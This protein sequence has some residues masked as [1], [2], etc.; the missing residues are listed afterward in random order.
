MSA[1]FKR[2]LNSLMLSGIGP[3]VTGAILAVLFLFFIFNNLMG[4][5]TDTGASM[6]AASV[7]ALTFAVPILCMR[8][9][10]GEK[11]AKTDQ[12]ILTAPVKVR[13]YVLGK[14]FALS[15]ILLIPTGFACFLSTLI[16]LFGNAEIAVSLTAVFGFYLYAV[17]L[18][19]ICMFLS[20]LTESP[21][22]AAMFSFI[23]ILLGVLLGGAYNN[24]PVLWLRRALSAV[25]NFS[26][27]LNSMMYGTLDVT[28]VVYFVS[29]TCLFLFLC[30]AAINKRRY[31]LQGHGRV[32]AAHSLSLIL[33]AS[34]AVMF[35]NIFVSS[36]PEEKMSIDVTSD[37]L[38]SL[39]DESKAVARSVSSPITLHFIAPEGDDFGKDTNIER[40]L[41]EFASENSLIKLSYE[42]PIINPRFYADYSKDE[43][44]SSSVVVVNE[45]NGAYRAIDANDM[46]LS[47]MDF[48][49]FSYVMTGYDTEGQIT[50]AL[51]YVTDPVDE[52][53]VAYTLTGHGESDIDPGFLK[54]VDR[55]LFTLDELDLDAVN[56][57]P[58]D[59]A[60]IIIN[61]PLRDITA[62]EK[63]S[64]VAYI[65]GGGDL[66]V[67]C[68]FDT[69]EK[70]DNLAEVLKLYGVKEK[71]G[72]VVETA[73]DMFYFA[74]GNSMPYYLFPK[75][76][77]DDMTT[78]IENGHLFVPLS[79][80]FEYDEGNGDTKVKPLITTSEI[81]YIHMDF[82]TEQNLARRDSDEEGVFTLALKAENGDSKAVIYGSSEMFTS[83]AD[84]LSTGNNARL[85]G[86]TLIALNDETALSVSIPIKR[87]NETL[88]VT[89]SRMM[90]ISA[91]LIAIVFIIWIA[92]LAVWL[93]RR[94]L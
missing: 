25:F 73:K 20:S 61:A 60:L 19:S 74:G 46:Q 26:D 83:D 76:A 36:L 48:E 55:A 35:V 18:V 2:E 85:F 24:I 94:K 62:K 11:R 6:N 77:T 28:T 5:A 39:C 23:I 13:D 87:I 14:F 31:I 70:T 84:E 58:E 33:F 30:S 59:A 27:R 3:I 29:V 65:K 44:S 4:L 12:L 78:S 75:I 66:F 41:K 50:G 8:S 52:R 42:D 17:M 57:V 15:A 67:I 90:L 63:D 40:L 49:T 72:I 79:E 34:S 54:Y 69:E 38:Y 22:V 43:L 51:M 80:A 89:A 7:L 64:L 82:D 16:N 10:A 92:G 81:A 45:D 68:R 91:I 53:A 1:V 93:R 9:F 86:N 71:K 21:I 37:R 47:T 56:A 88:H 32:M